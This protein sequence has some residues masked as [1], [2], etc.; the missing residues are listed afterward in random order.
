MDCD[1]PI[2]SRRATKEMNMETWS[3][4]RLA[5]IV[6]LASAAVVG[7]LGPATASDFCITNIETLVGKGFRLPPRGK[8]KPWL[9]YTVN[10]EGGPNSATGTA[11]T[12]A[13]GSHATIDVTTMYPASGDTIFATIMLPL[14][15]GSGAT[16]RE[17]GLISG[18]G[19]LEFKGGPST[20]A[21]PC[22]PT[23]P[24]P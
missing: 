7:S 16:L 8:C 14:P 1:Q 2:T 24:V 19:Y 12:A 17:S 20:T 18:T 15:L 11:C 3:R 22:N 4:P 13:D 9:G 23:P 6:I 21:G 10:G 5:L